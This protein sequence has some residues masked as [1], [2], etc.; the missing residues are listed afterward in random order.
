MAAWLTRQRKIPS[1]IRPGVMWS[2]RQL[3]G[4]EDTGELQI[5]RRRPQPGKVCARGA[6][7]SGSEAGDPGAS[8]T[9]SRGLV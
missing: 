1:E 7:L 6:V 5:Q 3:L 2:D 9:P 4:L 8:V